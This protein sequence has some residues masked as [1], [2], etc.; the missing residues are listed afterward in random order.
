MKK[1]LLI[2]ILIST[3]F[4]FSFR[5]SETSTWSV[6]KNHAKLGFTVTHMGISE[7]EGFFKTFDAKIT[8]TGTDFT[9]A[10]AEMTA[11]VNSLNT[12]NEMRD[13]DLK[14]SKYFDVVQY[15]VMTFKSK[16]FIKVSETTYKISGDITIHGVTRPVSLDVICRT[17]VHPMTKKPIAGFKITG[18]LNRSDFG[19][20]PAMSYTM[21]SD[22]ISLIA[23]AEF[24]KD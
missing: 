12:D 20:G 5:Q 3:A 9:N 24:Q 2:S 13:N 15:P 18:T 4:L 17:G 14:S 10:V 21:V 8:S 7:V 16:S 19:I 22:Q 6:D 1:F 11:D 23:N